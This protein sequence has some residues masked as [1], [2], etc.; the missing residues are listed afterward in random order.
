MMILDCT[1]R[2]GGYYTNWDFPDKVVDCYLSAMNRLPVDVIEVGYRNNPSKE[3]LG[4]FGYTPRYVLERIRQQCEKKIAVMINEKSTQPSDLPRLVGDLVGFIDTVRI[5][6]DP[7]RF[8]SAV[9][10]A[11]QCKT[12]GFD[13]GF[14]VMYMSTWSERDGFIDKLSSVG[15]CIDVLCMV[16]SFGGITPEEVVSICSDLK[17]RLSCRIGFHGHNNLQFAMAN[18]LA[19]V[20]AGCD[21]VDSTILGM[22]RGAGNLPTELLLTYLNSKGLDLDF[23]VLGDAV[24]AFQPLFE[25]HRWGTQ[26]PY[27]IAGANSLPQR[28]VMAMVTNRVYSFNSIVRGLQN[29]R[30]NILDNAKYPIFNDSHCDEVLIVGG[31]PSP[32]ENAEAL[33]HFVASR[34]SIAIIYATARYA[35][36]FGALEVPQYYCL[37]GRES[38]RLES[39]IGTTS[40]TSY[41]ILPP[42]PRTLGTEVPAMAEGRT[43]ELSEISFTDDFKDSCTTLALQTSLELSARTIWITGYDGYPSSVLSEKESSLTREN[44]MLFSRFIKY[45]GFRP[46]SLTNTLYTE[47]EP[48]SVYQML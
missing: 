8:D 18:T 15:D 37:V 48:R 44:R 41:C 5:S 33:R 17:N 24:A 42:Y 4:R 11:Q 13:V 3:Y 1:L 6:V 9:L 36:L 45:S 10:L 39:H 43:F 2:D 14:N 27:M 38:R 16:D 34:Q 21:V 47:L 7:S 46:I 28:E 12:M 40:F 30:N 35:G 23:N 29:R 19:A 26:L 32:I 20:S 25:Q 31:G 22:G